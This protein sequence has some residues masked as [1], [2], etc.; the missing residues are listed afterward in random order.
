MLSPMPART[1]LANS[2]LERVAECLTPD[3]ARALIDLR[4]DRKLQVRVDELAG[5]CNEGGLTPDEEAEYETFVSMNNF[6]AL[7]Q[8]KARTLLDRNDGR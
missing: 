1:S 2:L 7:L 5:K 4:V 3:A 8:S 6:I